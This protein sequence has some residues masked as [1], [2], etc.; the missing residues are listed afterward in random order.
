MILNANNSL[1]DLLPLSS[2]A[3]GL[4]GF[5]ISLH[6]LNLSEQVGVVNTGPCPLNGKASFKMQAAEFLPCAK[7]K[8]ELFT[9]RNK[10]AGLLEPARI[11]Q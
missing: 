9:I 2:P 6:L 10:G 5:R 3:S 8:A 7:T 11:P 1:A 4:T